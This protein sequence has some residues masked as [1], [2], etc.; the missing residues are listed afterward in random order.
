M[1]VHNALPRNSKQ[2]ISIPIKQ[3]TATVKAMSDDVVIH[4]Q[5]VVTSLPSHPSRHEEA[6]YKL[7]FTAELKP[8]VF[9]RFVVEQSPHI[10]FAAEL[11][12]SA[13][14][15]R[16]SSSGITTMENDFTRVEIDRSTGSLVSVYNKAEK[17]SLPVTLAILYY[18]SFQASSPKSGAYVFRPT[19]N[20]TYPAAE[21][22][23]SKFFFKL[24]EFV[25][26]ETK[27]NS[28]GTPTSVA[29][30]LGK[31]VTIV[32]KLGE[33]D[34][35]VEI[36]WTVGP[37][38]IDDHQG[39][40]VILRFDTNKAI[41]SNGRWYTDSNGLEFVERVRNYRATWN[42][43]LHD[44][45]E[46]V[47]ANYAPVT[48][49]AYIKDKAMQLNLVT[50]R[51]HGVGSLQDGQME[52]MVHR[53][54][55]A[56][57]SKGVHEHLN[58]TETYTDPQTKKTY[59]DGLIVRGSTFL[60][61]STVKEGMQ[62]IRTKMEKQFYHPLVL[63]KKSS[64]DEELLQMKLPWLR[65]DN[66]PP[67]L[68]LTTIEELSKKC[69]RVR[70]SHLYAVEEHSE[71]S[72]PIK[73]DFEQLFK[74]NNAKEK[75]LKVAEL[76]LAGTQEMRPQDDQSVMTRIASWRTEDDAVDIPFSHPLQGSK[77]ELQAMEVRTFKICFGFSWS[78]ERHIEQLHD[79]TSFK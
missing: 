5:K 77:V 11:M 61:L 54:L 58:E 64:A 36:E 28:Y 76:N 15:G 72:K 49:G 6:P 17:I 59:T 20:K 51:A 32:Y 73:V 21:I 75:V 14:R 16:R 1:Y 8:L 74:T 45:Q 68:G 9:H 4:N 7:E 34:E 65:V 66:F 48:T 18:R 43:T 63:F 42:L 78:D 30:R 56:D 2:T 31:W 10:P 24:V 55:V 71:L 46:F 25:D 19:S 26:V 70:L 37:I 3:S 35:F 40:E 79:R 44:D 12:Y 41:K 60:G 13:P 33:V 39:K 62:S 69:V 47:A 22:E 53:R 23:V 50:D 29:F 27:L 38:P 67:N 57:D 52:V